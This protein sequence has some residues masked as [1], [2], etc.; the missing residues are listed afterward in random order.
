MWRTGEKSAPGL[1]TELQ[2]LC[3]E[4]FISTDAHHTYSGFHN[5]VNRHLEA[6]G[7]EQ[8]NEFRSKSGYAI[9]ILVKL[10]DTEVVGLEVDGP[11]HF[12]RANQNDANSTYFDGPEIINTGRKPTARTML[13]RRLIP[14]NDQ[15]PLRSI[16]YWEWAELKGSESKQHYLRSLIGLDEGGR[17]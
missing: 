11:H 6:M 2:Q 13:R 3:Q 5:E 1:P 4:A 10:S 8:E 9:D 15:I 7:L 17:C 16:P 14:C 12:E